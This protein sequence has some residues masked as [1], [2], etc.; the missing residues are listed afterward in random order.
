MAEPQ[1]AEIIMAGE[2]WLIDR[3]CE[4]GVAQGYGRYTSTLR[5][6]WRL[7]VQGL[8]A[9]LIQDF[10]NRGVC[11]SELGP[12]DDYRSGSVAEFSI[13]EAQLHRRRGVPIEMFLGLFKYYRQGYEELIEQHAS[14]KARREYSH[15][16][17]RCFDRLE[18]G[19]IKEWTSHSNDELLEELQTQNRRL[20]NEKNKFLTAVESI[21]SPVILLDEQQQIEMLNHRAVALFVGPQ[22]PGAFYYRSHGL[23]PAF[24]WLA[25]AI[26][27]NRDIAT[28]ETRE[29]LRTFQLTVARMLDVSGKF[30]S[31]VVALSDITERE[32]ARI[33][34][35][36]QSDLLVERVAQRTEELVRVNQDLRTEIE[37]RKRAEQQK[38]RYF[39]ELLHSQKLEALGSLA[40]GMAHDLNNILQVIVGDLELLLM[41]QS[42]S[43]EPTLLLEM[44]QAAERA[45]SLVRQLLLFGR[46]QPYQMRATAVNDVVREMLRLLNRLLPENV[47]LATT[48]DEKIPPVLGDRMALEQVIL[49]LVVNARDALPDGG[50]ILVRTRRLNQGDSPSD[51][52]RP[53][54]VELSVEDNGVGIPE[55]VIQRIFDPFF[56]TKE[57]GTGLGLSVVRGVAEALGGRLEVESRVRQGTIIRLLMPQADTVAPERPSAPPAPART[58]RDAR[59]LLVED[60]TNVRALLLRA[61]ARSGYDVIAVP[62]A[63]T[64]LAEFQRLDAGVT[65]VISDG[66]LPGMSGPQMVLEMLRLAANTRAIFISGYVRESPEWEILQQRGFPMLSKPIA[67]H[68]LLDQLN[69]TLAN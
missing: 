28:V 53:Q 58:R 19:F 29:G 57:H 15:A 50:S 14:P 20:T 12:D 22:D 10:R 16:L 18:L 2:E 1:L 7:S 37:E 32:E 63:E 33:V 23:G 59:I 45:V 48:L 35:E 69:R 36:K 9:S 27:N 68:D 67:I 13:R 62:D 21:P 61:L 49:N 40:G 4:L 6:A 64:A 55:S 8:S 44:S 65:C 24:P 43:T 47:R 66:M 3:I 25:Q 11:E 30:T 60:D 34:L 46:G 31:M 54:L 39:Q 56:T 17:N 42:N 41:D 51:A 5:E 52:A 26:E 38:D